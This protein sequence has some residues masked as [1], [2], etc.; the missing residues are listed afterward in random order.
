M[1]RSTA[2]KYIF[3]DGIMTDNFYD[4]CIIFSHSGERLPF[5]VAVSRLDTDRPWTFPVS[6]V[7]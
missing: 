1:G 2:N 6:F 3:K 5:D 4:L 7:K